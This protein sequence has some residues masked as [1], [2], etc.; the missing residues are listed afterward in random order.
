ML[1]CM[2]T[3]LNLNDALMRKAKKTAA[4]SGRTLTAIIEAALR[5][6]LQ[7]KARDRTPLPALPVSRKRGGLQP[8]VQISSTSELLHELDTEDAHF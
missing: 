1:I 3:T 7:P 8:G 4:A 5:D 6:Y 2:R